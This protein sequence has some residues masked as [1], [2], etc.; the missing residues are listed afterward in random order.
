[1]LHIDADF[2]SWATTDRLNCY[3]T[4]SSFL[5]FDFFAD[6][7]EKTLVSRYTFADSEF[8]VAEWMM[9]GRISCLLIFCF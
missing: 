3:V 8:P 5:F 6:W 7:V 9:V 1:M 4:E 2:A